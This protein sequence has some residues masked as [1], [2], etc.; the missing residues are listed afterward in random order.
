MGNL[1]YNSMIE[2]TGSRHDRRTQILRCAKEVFS[3]SGFH[4]ASVA[5]LI[6]EAGIARGTFYLYFASKRAIFDTLL[7]NL[8]QELRTRIQPIE[9]GPGKPEPLLQLKANIRRVLELVI[10]E[11]ELIQILLHQAS[12]ADKQ[13][14]ATIRVFYNRVQELTERALEHGKRIGLI[15][16][17]DSRIVAACILGSVKEVADWLTARRSE[18]PAMDVLV[19]EIVNFGLGGLLESQTVR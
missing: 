5:D 18:P 2:T 7:Q 17:C 3:K 15:R 11:P 19:E 8:L 13:A 9:L 16:P 12:G 4:N 1:V 10:Q 6:D 14:A